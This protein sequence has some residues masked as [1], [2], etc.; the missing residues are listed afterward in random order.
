MGT[1]LSTENEM[2]LL[3]GHF[4]PLTL[5]RDSQQAAGCGVFLQISTPTR[6]GAIVVLALGNL[7]VAVSLVLFLCSKNNSVLY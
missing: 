3:Q 6:P 2:L 7:D 5:G 4:P 1:S